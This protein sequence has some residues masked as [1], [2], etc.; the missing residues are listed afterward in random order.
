M[1]AGGGHTPRSQRRGVEDRNQAPCSGNI[2]LA[3]TVKNKTPHI[4]S[5]L[6]LC[7]E[8]G[9]GVALSFAANDF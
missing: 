3:E 4:S 2:Q 1:G 5:A 8:V 9:G 6:C 7:L